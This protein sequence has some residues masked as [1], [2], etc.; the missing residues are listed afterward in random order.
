MSTREEFRDRIEGFL[1]DL[2]DISERRGVFSKSE[3][4]L[5]DLACK[6][7]IELAVERLLDRTPVAPRKLG[8]I[9]AQIL[10]IPLVRRILAEHP[11][12]Q[13]VDFSFESGDVDNLKFKL[14]EML[15]VLEVPA[16]ST[17]SVEIP[18]APHRKRG[19]QTDMERH[20][21][22]AGIVEPYGQGWKQ[23]S[24]LIRIAAQLDREGVSV[25]K[26]W[27]EQGVRK[28]NR[29]VTSCPEKM[30]KAIDYSRLMAER[31]H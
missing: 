5:F 4:P 18:A 13:A 20:R 6:I 11:Y 16:E 30:V 8:Q 23:E 21:K 26:S 17:P 10:A 19:P 7:H 25:R 9:S 31:N 2:Q 3:T 29:A 27:K 12:V 28:W 15:E 22:I 24:N 1:L 14:R